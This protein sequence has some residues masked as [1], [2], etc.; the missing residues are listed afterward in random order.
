MP[1]DR[2]ALLQLA[3]NVHGKHCDLD[4]DIDLR[5]GSSKSAC[6]DLFG[7]ALVAYATLDT[8]LPRYCL[9]VIMIFTNYVSTTQTSMSARASASVRETIHSL[10]WSEGLYVSM[11]QRAMS[12]GAS[13]SIRETIHS[14]KC[15]A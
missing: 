11:I 9:S 14:L 13:A 7:A 3:L 4:H 6:L 2:R 5:T 15:Y 8:R 12:A 10:M 1:F